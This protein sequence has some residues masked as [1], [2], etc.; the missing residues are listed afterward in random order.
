MHG[1]ALDQ[2]PAVHPR[3]PRAAHAVTQMGR[4]PICLRRR[5]GSCRDGASRAYEGFQPSLRQAHGCPLTGALNARLRSDLALQTPVMLRRSVFPPSTPP[6]FPA[7]ARDTAEFGR[8]TNVWHALCSTSLE[9]SPGS[10]IRLA[11]SSPKWRNV[12]CR[13]RPPSPR[14]S[15]GGRTRDVGL[16][17]SEENQEGVPLR[18]PGAEWNSPGYPAFR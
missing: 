4:P 2:A 16:C 13:I 18:V 6:P 11:H 14:L 8:V 5:S 1:A 10:A 17:I 12:Q 3:Y 15:C 9:H 7:L